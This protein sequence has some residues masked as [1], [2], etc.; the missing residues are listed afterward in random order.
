M[1]FIQIL[2]VGLYVVRDC[3]VSL[4]DDN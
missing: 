1:K 3:T 4:L 2:P